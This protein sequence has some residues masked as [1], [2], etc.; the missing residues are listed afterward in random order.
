MTA[1][2]DED[3][4]RRILAELRDEYV[5]QHGRATIAVA[6]ALLTVAA[7]IRHLRGAVLLL[8]PDAEEA[9]E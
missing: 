6:H 3:E 1:L 4:A 5:S 8:R 7:E 2:S 9:G